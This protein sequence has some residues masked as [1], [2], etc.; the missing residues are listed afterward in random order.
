MSEMLNVNN[1]IGNKLHKYKWTYSPQSLWINNPK[2]VIIMD[3]FNEEL[4]YFMKK[5]K[6]K[7]KIHISNSTSNKDTKLS[8]ESINFLM[9]FYKKDFE[10]FEKYKNINLEERI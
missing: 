7:G 6:L 3:N 9:N 1:Y 10:L 4:K 2:F 8:I 5:Y